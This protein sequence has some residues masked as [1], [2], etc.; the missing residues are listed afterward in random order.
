MPGAQG[1]QALLQEREA[2]EEASEGAHESGATGRG[3][4]IVDLC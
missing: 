4:G 1:P 2:G 3:G